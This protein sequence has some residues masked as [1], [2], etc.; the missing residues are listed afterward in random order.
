MPA[1]SSFDYAVIRVVPHVER[2]EFVNAGVILF[3][4]TRGFLGIR[5]A[6]D[7]RRLAALAP[8]L[9][10]EEAKAHLAFLEQVCRGDEVAGPI[11]RLPLSARFHWLTSPRS[12]IIQTSPVHS[13]LS[14]DPEAALDR[15]LAEMVL[16]QKN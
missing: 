7:E 14:D 6:L 11:G 3:A 16:P 8:D 15:L 2:G 1:L 12:T 5:L 13:G 10:L 4:R 9:D